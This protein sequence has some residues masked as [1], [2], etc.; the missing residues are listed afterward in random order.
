MPVPNSLVYSDAMPKMGRWYEL[1]K[2]CRD[3]DGFC[4]QMNK[5]QGYFQEVKY[6]YTM[7]EFCHPIAGSNV[8]AYC[9]PSPG[10]F[11]EYFPT[12]LINPCELEIKNYT[13]TY[14]GCATACVVLYTT[15]AGGTSKVL[16][17]GGESVTISAQ[18]DSVKVTCPLEDFN[19]VEE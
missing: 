8:S 14:N 18:V 12:C 11:M 17:N 9:R 10:R 1:I 15:P 7:D 2:P 4:I 6:Y 16:V 19:I 13:I 5:P 3:C